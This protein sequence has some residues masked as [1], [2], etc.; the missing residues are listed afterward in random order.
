MGNSGKKGASQNV[1]GQTVLELV[2]GSLAALIFGF[3]RDIVDLLQLWLLHVDL[4]LTPADLI[5][6]FE[7]MDPRSTCR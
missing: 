6:K 2:Y 1:T 3:R 5:D 7:K 4:I